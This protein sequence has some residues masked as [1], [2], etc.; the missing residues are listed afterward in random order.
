MQNSRIFWGGVLVLIGISLLGG[1]IF[2]YNAWQTIWT[3]APL[4]LIGLGIWIYLRHPYSIIVAL[5][6]SVFGLLL[7]LGNLG[8]VDAHI[9]NLWPLLL[10]AAGLNVLLKKG[11]SEVSGDDVETLTETTIFAGS[12]K[13]ISSR[14]FKSAKLTNIFG[15]SELDLSNADLK[16]DVVIEAVVMF[17]GVK[18]F[19][20]E[21]V[22][23]RDD[24]TKIAA[25]V[26]NTYEKR[27]Q[28]KSST[29]QVNITI[30]GVVMFGG[31]EIY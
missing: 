10:I 9:F 27:S 4:L 29:S 21:G 6:I 19:L 16:D 13:A 18:I 17:G 30:K 11:D 15:G 20:P 5:L 24:I 14:K 2:D 26:K 28:K 25:D 7:F 23:L 8:L 22:N 1:N 12:K 31:I 3:V